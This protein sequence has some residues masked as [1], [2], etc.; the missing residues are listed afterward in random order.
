[1]ALIAYTN[2]TDTNIHIGGKI[3]TPN[4]T[5]E[6][7]DSFLNPEFTNPPETEET[8]NENPLVELL[9]G[10]VKAITEGIIAL[11]DEDL[12]EL[13]ALETDSAKPRTSVLE[14]INKLQLTRA[15]S[16]LDAG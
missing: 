9:K 11:T 10:N 4:N 6:I 2:N 15:D 13:E 5:R 8:V 12:I 1:M 14:A 16:G 7:D 3:I